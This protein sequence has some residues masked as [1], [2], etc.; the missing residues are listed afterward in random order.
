LSHQLGNQSIF[1]GS[2]IGYN[3]YGQLGPFRQ[4]YLDLGYFNGWNPN[5]GDARFRSPRTE[6]RIS[7]DGMVR[8]RNKWVFGW[9]ATHAFERF[10]D[11]ETRRNQ[12]VLLYRR[13]GITGVFTRVRSDDT[14]PFWMQVKNF[15]NY[16]GGTFTINPGL[17]AN[18]LVGGR[19]ELSLNASWSQ[20]F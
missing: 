1:E 7:L 4:V 10:D 12:L 18:L 2:H 3:R 6:N 16:E 15:F 19:I 17:D 20:W 13:P 14:R 9:F 8:F 11:W 5:A